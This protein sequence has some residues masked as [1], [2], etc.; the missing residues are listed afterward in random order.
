MRISETVGPR[1]TKF[2]KGIDVDDPKVDPEGQGHRSR[3]PGVKHDFLS[4]YS[5]Q[6]PLRKSRWAHVNIK[7]H[8]S[9]SSWYSGIT[10][11]MAD[12]LQVAKNKMVRFIKSM[13]PRTHISQEELSSIGMLD[14]KSRVKQLRLNHAYKIYNN[15][16]PQYLV[17]NF[18][19]VSEIHAYG[20]RFSV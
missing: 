6:C 13:E 8:F 4:C 20:T 5:V 1:V 9:C 17:E 14:V 15:S 3:S 16:S 7:L 2:G 11:T 18:T 12:K 10:Q 19:Q